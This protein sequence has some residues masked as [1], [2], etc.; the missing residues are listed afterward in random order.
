MCGLTSYPKSK[1][2]KAESTPPESFLSSLHT[3]LTTS[4][5]ALS[6]CCASVDSS[7]LIYWDE[8][9]D[10]DDSAFTGTSY[11]P[12]AH[13]RR[14]RLLLQNDPVHATNLMAFIKEHLALMQNNMGGPDRFRE[15]CLRNVDDALI[16]QMNT[17]FL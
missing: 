1:T 17:M 7:A 4:T 14:K 10:E 8:D 11:A 15:D 2:P 13:E 16:D 12:S 9:E 3:R 6:D 5:S